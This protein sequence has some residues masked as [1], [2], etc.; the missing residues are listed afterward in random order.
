VFLVDDFKGG[1]APSALYWMLKIICF[2]N[3]KVKA[4]PGPNKL[5]AFPATY[6]NQMTGLHPAWDMDVLRCE[7]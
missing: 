3:Q 5:A 7:K 6:T 2:W 1:S 4:L